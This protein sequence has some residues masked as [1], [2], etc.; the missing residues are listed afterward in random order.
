MIQQIEID[1]Q[2]YLQST[3]EL[4]TVCDLLWKKWKDAK[5]DLFSINSFCSFLFEAQEW[6]KIILISISQIKK[7]A[8]VSWDF[9]A[10]TLNKVSDQQFKN[11]T[12]QACIDLFQSPNHEIPLL[13]TYVF[14]LISPLPLDWRNYFIKQEKRTRDEMR[15]NL[16]D[17]L[18]MFK[19]STT[20]S[21]YE[22]NVL[23]K[24]EKTYPHDSEVKKIMEVSKTKEFKEILGKYGNTFFSEKFGYKPDIKAESMFKTS[25]LNDCKKLIK[26]P[27]NNPFDFV[28]LFIFIEAYEEALEILEREPSSEE[29]NWLVMELLMLA[30]RYTQALAWTDLLEE[31]NI[32]KYDLDKLSQIYYH[33]ARCLWELKHKLNAIETLENLLRCNP[34]YRIANHLLYEWKSVV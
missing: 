1:I 24:L 13:R 16:I 12:L 6:E 25:L 28:Y 29:N 18:H 10:E 26:D 33:R 14:D 8:P 20:F 9:L 15:T 2:N 11:K 4:T 21:E 19:H 7:T 34:E 32:Q 17:Q 31:K 27:E 5:F 23:I 3:K 22:K 30:K